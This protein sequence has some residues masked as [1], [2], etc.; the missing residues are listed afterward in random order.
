M[1]ETRRLAA[2]TAIDVVGYSRLMGE[3]EEGTARAVREH[4]E[5]ARPLVTGRGGRV[6]KAMG[7]GLLLEFPSVVDAVECAIAIQSLMVERNA[8]APEGE[9]RIAGDDKELPKFGESGD[10]VF[11][12]AVGEIFLFRVAAHVL[13]RQHCNRRLVR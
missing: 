10:D 6:V 4:R 3:D 9:R 5:A 2:I 1:T 13:E 12:D 11:R 7:D 8:G